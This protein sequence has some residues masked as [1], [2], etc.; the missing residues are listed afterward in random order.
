MAT[1]YV[2]KEEAR[3]FNPSLSWESDTYVES[4]INQAEWMI[5]SYLWEYNFASATIT[6][7]RHDLNAE[8]PY[9]FKY[10]PTWITHIGWSAVTATEWTHY[11]AKWRRIMFADTTLLDN[12]ENTTFWYIT[13][14]YTKSS[15]IPQNI[16]TAS[17]ILTNELYTSKWSN[18]IS[19]YSQWD[20]TIKYRDWGFGGNVESLYEIKKLLSAYKNINVVS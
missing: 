20:F 13:F 4:I 17:L 5:D 6:N 19:E 15:T 9:Y 14:T 7:E 1:K 10:T 12:K 3:V 11:M 8:W 16:K 18:A 2:T